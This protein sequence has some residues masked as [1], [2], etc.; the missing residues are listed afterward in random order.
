[1]YIKAHVHQGTQAAHLYIKGKRVG[2]RQRPGPQSLGRHI[3]GT[4]WA[5]GGHR[6]GTE[7]AT[8]PKSLGPRLEGPVHDKRKKNKP[9][10]AAPTPQ[11]DTR[12]HTTTAKTRE[13]MG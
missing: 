13:P 4:D 9:R 3:Q 2:R 11:R 10:M 6:E 5:Q 12:N 7:S 8:W 1:M